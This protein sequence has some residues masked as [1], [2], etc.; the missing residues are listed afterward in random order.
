M[1]TTK[2]L[3]NA[4]RVGH[5][6]ALPILSFPAASRLN[7]TVKEL[8]HSAQLQA[9][10]I[11]Y[12][13]THTPTV[14]AVS[15]MDLSVEA[16]A[17]GAK[18]RFADNEVPAITGQL[19]SDGDEAD[20]LEVP[21]LSKGRAQ[22]CVEAVRQAKRLIQDRPVLAGV[23]GPYSL[24]GRLMD[25]TEIFY[26][27]YDEPEVVHTV[28]NKAEAY[29]SAYIEAF[30]EAG[31]DGVVMAE[32]LAGL[33]SPEMAGEFSHSV[34]K[35]IIKRVQSENFPV[36]YHNCGN[37]VAAMLPQ[38]FDLGAAAYHFG[39]VLNMAEVM[40]QAPSG[41]LCMGNIDPAGQFANGSSESIREATRQLM[42]ECGG[43]A[44]FIPSSG[45]DIPAHANW[46]NIKSFF[47]AV[48]ESNEQG[49]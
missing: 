35:R 25:V 8:V 44:N 37:T 1:N 11:E 36:V 42:R 49:A 31:A 23:I 18:A 21:D 38:V 45:C 5:K 29:I 13:A 39:N 19:V 9:Q 10:A 16:E 41:A 26:T 32:P 27:C 4:A 40:K 17:F 7:V 30:R 34:V 33:L 6:G 43:Y 3:W 47:D 22:L 15:L 48:A 28:L 46:D 2:F 14:A 24:A 20:A 12:V